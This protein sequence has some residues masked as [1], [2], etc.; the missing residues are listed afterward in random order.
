MAAGQRWQQPRGHLD[1]ALAQG[2]V[3]QAVLGGEPAFWVPERADGWN[4]GGDRLWLGPER[5]WFW[6]GEDHDDL[7]GHV[8]PPEIDPGP[9]RVD[10]VGDG[11]ADLGR[12]ANLRNRGTGDTTTVRL[13]REIDLLDTGPDRVDYRVRTTLDVLAGPPGQQV[14]AWSVLQVPDG[15]T[16]SV[17]LSAPL[18]YRDYL[19]P[20]DPFQIKEFGDRAELR[21]T[22]ERMFKIGLRPDVV[23]GGLRY[24]RPV[25]GGVLH[26]DRVID[27]YPRRRYCDLPSGVDTAGQG[28]AVQVFDDDGHYGGYAEIEHHSPA[29]VMSPDG[30]STVVDVCRTTVTLTRS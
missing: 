24:S 7:A 13:R 26:V 14:S 28:D 12:T 10:H 15:G 16:L 8:V 18:S 19:Q 4:L 11:H 23:A 1:L 30:P 2:R 6:A 3:L 9:W 25:A 22:G 29:V 5:D 20:L 21:L 27:V 17:A